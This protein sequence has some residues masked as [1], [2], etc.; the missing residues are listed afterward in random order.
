MCVSSMQHMAVKGGGGL[1]H[2]MLSLLTEAQL[3]SV[4]TVSFV[5][6]IKDEDCRD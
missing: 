2:V 6:K 3:F 5:H 4:H 1:D